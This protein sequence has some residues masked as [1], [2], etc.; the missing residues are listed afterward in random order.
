MQT[1]VAPVW[2][3][4]LLAVESRLGVAQVEASS[5]LTVRGSSIR[6]ADGCL[7]AGV[8]DFL[9][10]A[11]TRSRLVVDRAQCADRCRGLWLQTADS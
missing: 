9:V 5:P 8:D 6:G 1:H 7:R 11:W 2:T 10:G 4:A 3:F